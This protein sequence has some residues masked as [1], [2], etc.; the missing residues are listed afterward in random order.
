[1]SRDLLFEIGIEELPSSYVVPAVEQLAES[2]RRGLTDL[3]LS[4]GEVRLF[5]TPRRFALLVT[6]VTQGSP[7][8]RSLVRR[9]LVPTPRPVAFAVAPVPARRQAKV[10]NLGALRRL[11][12]LRVLPDVAD[13]LHL[14]QHGRSPFGL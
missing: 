6:G 11:A 14:V 1:M 10:S 12:N 9:S 3:R 4:Y 2:A 8:V 7:A 13:E 5:A